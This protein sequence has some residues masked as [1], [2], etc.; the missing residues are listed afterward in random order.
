MLTIEQRIK[1]FKDGGYNPIHICGNWY[2]IRR[3][4]RNYCKISIYELVHLK[5]EE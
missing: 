3:R 1:R 5:E 2:F 4:S